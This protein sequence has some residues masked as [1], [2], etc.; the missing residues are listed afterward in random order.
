MNLVCLCRGAELTLQLTAGL[1][2]PVLELSVLELRPLEH[3]SWI[4]NTPDFED[5]PTVTILVSWTEIYTVESVHDS[6]AVR[7]SCPL[8][9]QNSF[10]PGADLLPSDVMPFNINISQFDQAGS[11]RLGTS[12]DA[13][14]L[15]RSHYTLT[16]WRLTLGGKGN[17]GMY[18]CVGG[19]SWCH[20]AWRR[21]LVVWCHWAPLPTHDGVWARA[22]SGMEHYCFFNS[23]PLVS[24]LIFLLI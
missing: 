16:T 8:I 15:S 4:I 20:W 10:P 5:V 17:H 12:G 22:L 24:F 13:P 11:V 23:Y 7:I 2:A 1:S 3:V 19:G 18:P 14:E 6:P 9:V 21:L